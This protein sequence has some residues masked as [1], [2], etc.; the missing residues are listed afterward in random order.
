MVGIAMI[1]YNGSD[2]LSLTLDS[3]TRACVDTPFTVCLVDNASDTTD[4][5][6]ARQ[7]FEAFASRAGTSGK[8]RL[9]RS[10]QNLGFA[11][12]S[13]LGCQ[14]LLEDPD[15]ERVCFLNSDVIVTDH[16]LDRLMESELDMVAPVT[17]ANGNEQTIWVDY[18]A[19]RDF[20]AY[21]QVAEFGAFRA[22]V[23]A[24]YEIECESVTAFC[25]L[26][27]RDAL[28]KAAPFDTQFFPGGFEDNDFCRRLVQA[29]GRIG[30]RRDCYIH[31]W[32]GGS[33]SKLELD[34]RIGISLANMRRYE[35]KW[36]TLWTGVQQQLPDSLFQ[37]MRFLLE[38][39]NQE[40]RAL[41][42]LADTN[43]AIKMLLRGY[44][45]QR[46]EA[47]KQIY[48]AAAENQLAQP[49]PQQTEKGLEQ[50]TSERRLTSVPYFPDPTGRSIGMSLVSTAGGLASG[51][52]GNCVGGVK[53]L[54]RGA[55]L[56]YHALRAP[57]RRKTAYREVWQ[58]IENAQRNAKGAVA[59][60][61]P[62]YKPEN[63]TDGYFQR[64]YAVDQHVLGEYAKVY[65]EYF[66]QTSSPICESIDDRHMV[67][68]GDWQS[69]DYINVLVSIFR[70]CGV[71]YSHSLLKCCEDVLGAEVLRSILNA[72]D[73][74][75][76]VDM[77]GSIP[78]EA[79]L[80]DNWRGAQTYGRIEEV[81]M[82]GANVM[83]CVNHAMLEHFQEKYDYLKIKPAPVVMPIYLDEPVDKAAIERKL[84]DMDYARP[85][86]VYA[87][88]LH[89]WQNIPLMQDVMAE[90]GDRFRYEML[91]SDP[92]EFNRMYGTRGKLC[93][94]RVRRVPPQEVL[95]IYSRCQYGFVLRDDII[96]NNVA[97]PT[98]L[99]EYIRYGVLPVIKT[100][101]IGD[102]ARYG[103]EA[104][105]CEDFRAGRIPDEETYKRMI[106]HNL[107]VLDAF[108]RDYQ[109]GRTELL[110]LIEGR[111][112]R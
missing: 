72:R 66:P 62:I 41:K 109:S 104:I 12:G 50:E 60:L 27:K 91:V 99:I 9:I 97:C 42:L 51:L 111:V 31:H 23:Y 86:A 82:T 92:A 21:E 75:L 85:V 28:Q 63:L 55:K 54:Y 90:A 48:A 6:Q 33:F 101:R 107:E 25:A 78:E 37:D 73:I 1:N 110:R 103:M 88:G 108:T 43:D 64:I 15:I 61:A 69:P 4:Y 3:L 7:S 95:E 58:F 105:S 36:N 87:G 2:I 56:G 74:R 29:D 71:V 22:S 34:N 20:S 77:H 102:F 30:I 5:M 19:K 93:E 96:V 79:A 89:K 45:S 38:H 46:I 39:G 100:D 32:G 65:I 40:L 59:V 70:R 14:T 84:A 76:V 83:I 106:R 18:E 10:E 35:M 13:N 81:L 47:E 17:N 98:K 67:L 68:Y 53:A 57:A 112:A 11:G 94:L 26:V 8:D 80:Y 52:A 24:G 44:E 16:W 49:I